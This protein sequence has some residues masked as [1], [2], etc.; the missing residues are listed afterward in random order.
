MSTNIEQKGILVIGGGVCGIQSALDLGD[1]GYRVYLVEKEPSIGGHMAQLDKTFPTLDCSACILTPKMVD[2]SRHSNIQLMAY[3]EIE[4]ISGEAGDFRVKVR[5]KARYVDLKKCT[6][7][8]ECE[9]VCPVEVR[10]E[11]NLGLNNR[12]QIYRLF[13]QAVPNA[14]LIDKRGTPNCRATCP[15]GVN[16]QGYVALISQGKYDE[17]TA[18]VRQSIPLP[19][20]LGRVCFHPCESE[21]ERG[22]LDQPLTICSLKRFAADHAAKKDKV[23]PIPKSH[24]EKVAIVGSGPAGLTA[25]YELVKQGYPVTIFEALPAPGGMLRAGIPAYRLPRDVLDEEIDYIKNLGVEIKTNVRI[26]QDITVEDLMRE[27]NALFVAPG[28]PNGLKLDI[29]GEDSHGVVQALDL[30]RE[31]NLGNGFKLGQRVAIIGGGNVAIDASRIA[32]RLG[33]KEVKILYRRSRDEMPAY[34]H[35]VKEAENEGATIHFLVAPKRILS[36]NGCVTGIECIKLNLGEPDESGRRKPVPVEGSEFII[37]TDTV[38]E[39]IGQQTDLSF[40]P[41]VKIGKQ[42]TI[43][44]DP[45]TLETNVRGIFAGGDVSLGPASVIEAIADGKNAAVSIDR[46][47][48]GEDIKANRERIIDKVGEVSKEG[49]SPKARAEMPLLPVSERIGNFREVELGLTEEQ[50]MAEAKRCLACGGCS[51]CLQCEKACEA[52]AITHDQEDE[53]VSLNV[54]SII[55]ATG[56]DMYDVSK[57]VEYGYQKYD[58]VITGL[59]FERLINAGGPTSG[60]LH[61]NSDG[62]TPKN[63]AFIQC[64]GSRDKKSGNL[65]CSRVCCMYAIKQAV[66]IKEHYPETNVT[67]F[68]MDIRAFGKNFEEFYQ[69]AINEFKI[70]FVRGAVAEVTEDPATKNLK[71]KVED[72][73][74]G[75]LLDEE[76]DMVILSTG[77]QPAKS[78]QALN[79]LLGISNGSDGFFATSQPE[80]NSVYSPKE[81]IFIAG[82]AECAKD[83][84]DSIAQASAA[85]MK[86]AI[87]AGRVKTRTLTEASN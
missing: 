62:K 9:K 26:G 24:D 1:M 33:S 73:D 63:I 57:E 59:E 56:Y 17:A 79:A 60:H 54:S 20:V 49:F 51:E 30:L 28:A 15:A 38:I 83:I 31:V 47:V 70:R 61:K 75:K 58:N 32:L 7:C 52:K 13:P 44:V 81:G 69:R 40:V 16:V 41:E 2:V 34:P 29:E 12:K 8:G 82:A 48:R 43:V 27:H 77:L 35:E 80:L 74:T 10:N 14:F 78:S 85:A 65:N 86:A 45:L 19:G 25:A 46:F 64:I 68:Y 23:Q 22:K 55:V 72:S 84:P 4:S 71:L 50:A 66:L 53:P 42:K 36:K 87:V 21:C 3:S 37:E 6:G 39:A 5:K 67:I 18:L 76:F 11:F